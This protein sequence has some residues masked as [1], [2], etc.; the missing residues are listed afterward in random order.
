MSCHD[1][2]HGM[3]SLMKKM[4]KLYDDGVL[5]SSAVYPVLEV[6]KSGTYCCDGNLYE[7]MEYMKEH[8][9]ILC[10]R[11]SDKV[12]L[13]DLWDNFDSLDSDLQVFL[14]PYKDYSVCQRCLDDLKK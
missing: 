2:G 11:E 3:S 14:E 4:M 1:I 5:P 10:L 8:R 9:C 6:I 13:V 12:E 7:T